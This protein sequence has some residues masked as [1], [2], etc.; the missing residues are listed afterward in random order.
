MSW[1]CPWAAAIAA[2]AARLRVNWCPSGDVAG[3]GNAGGDGDDD[4]GAGEDGG[5]GGE[6]QRRDAAG[7]GRSGQAGGGLV[8][9]YAATALDNAPRAPSMRNAI[10]AAIF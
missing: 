1:P 2:A 6:G 8:G 7:Q 4:H 10:S 9:R 5:R 3:Q